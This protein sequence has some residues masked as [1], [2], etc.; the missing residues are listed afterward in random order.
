MITA[1]QDPYVK[2]LQAL[3]ER[4]KPEIAIL[5]FRDLGSNKKEWS[6]EIRPHNLKAATL[7]GNIYESGLVLLNV[8]CTSMEIQPDHGYGDTQQIADIEEICEAVFHGDFSESVISSG[9]HILYAC[10]TFRLKSRPL[11]SSRTQLSWR[12][13]L[14][15]HKSHSTQY[16]P[17]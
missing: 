5:Y 13:L 9:E 6:F 17:Y 7:S 15:S 14:L 4:F 1:I 8:A 12:W 3:T 11:K 2:A 10:G 16:E